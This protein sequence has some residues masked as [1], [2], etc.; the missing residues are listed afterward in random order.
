M[1]QRKFLEKIKKFKK[2]ILS[3][4]KKQ[5]RD[6]AWRQTTNPYNILVSEIMLQQTQTTRVVKKYDEFLSRFPTLATLAEAQLK[7]VLVLWQ[8]LGYNRRARFLYEGAKVIM[9]KYGG[10]FPQTYK[11]L[12]ELP[13]IGQSTTG[14]IMNFSFNIPTP[15]IETNIRT[16]FIHHFFSH[17]P[18]KAS[19]QQKVSDKEL[20]ELIEQT[21]DRKN[22]RDWFYALYDYGT[23]LKSMLDTDPAKKSAGY[24][25]QSTFRG[26][27]RQKRAQVLRYILKTSTTTVDEISRHF[28]FD[29]PMTNEVISSLMKD[30]LVEK[31]GNSI[32]A[33]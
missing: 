9:E 2:D 8:G 12:I 3:F 5:K 23:Y 30:K 15:F 19:T 7:D 26:S 17:K 27:F 14:A 25:K 21:I 29:A 18:R 11:E 6:F 33:A 32:M 20:L 10:K 22:P 1:P 28:V 31:S 16:V 13:G 4:Y 24:K